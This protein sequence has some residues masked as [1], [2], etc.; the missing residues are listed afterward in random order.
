MKS[1]RAGILRHQIIN[2]LLIA[3]LLVQVLLPMHFH[4]HHDA[5]PGVQGHK[6]VVDSHVLIDSKATEHL[7]DGETHTLKSTP[8]AIA[9]HKTDTG[10]IFA[11]MVCLLVLLPLAL[12]MVNRQWR[13]IREFVHHS[14]YY[15]LAPPLRAPPA[16]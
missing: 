5:D 7:A 4:L 12:L 13:D 1:L 11:L 14:F 9:K 15:Y 16:V 8:D 10:V 3:A 2:R 6:H